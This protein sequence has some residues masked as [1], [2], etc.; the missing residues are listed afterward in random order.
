MLP[1]FECFLPAALNYLIHQCAARFRRSQELWKNLLL[2]P[3]IRH[4]SIRN[5]DDTIRN[6]QDSLL[7]GNNYDGAVDF[8]AHLFKYPNQV[9]EAP[10]VDPRLRLVENRELCPTRKHHRDLNSL[11]LAAGQRGV[12]LPVDIIPGAQAHL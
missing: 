7:M 3:L 2:C 11:Q 9:V 10:E 4:L 12:Y 8:P 6:I 5:H 1:Q